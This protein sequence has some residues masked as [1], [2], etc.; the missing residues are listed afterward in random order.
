MPVEDMRQ[1]LKNNSKNYLQQDLPNHIFD[2]YIIPSRTAPKPAEKA[3]LV[4]GSQKCKVL[5]V[6]RNRQLVED[7][8]TAIKNTTL[9]ADHV[10]PG[11]IVPVNAF[12]L[13]S[14]A[15]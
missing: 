14:Q 7:L 6:G 4:A 15:V 3:K 13:A 9:I 11:L 5:V 12:A 10:V 1:V 8:Q 2:C